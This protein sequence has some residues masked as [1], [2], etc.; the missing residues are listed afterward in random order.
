MPDRWSG[1]WRVADRVYEAPGRVIDAVAEKLLRP[2]GMTD[3]TWTAMKRFQAMSGQVTDPQQP[4]IP[5]GS[6]ACSGCK[7]E[8]MSHVHVLRSGEACSRC[9]CPQFELTT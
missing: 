3:G 1:F 6:T 7:H 5:V 8:V 9:S 4:Y 2:P